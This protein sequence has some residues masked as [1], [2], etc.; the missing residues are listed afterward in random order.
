MRPRVGLVQD[1]GR[2]LQFIQGAFDMARKA[3][4]PA[5][6][7]APPKPRVS[8]APEGYTDLPL[9]MPSV[10][11]A[12]VGEVE[13]NVI[14]SDIY[15]GEKGAKRVIIL[16]LGG[17]P[18]RVIEQGGMR[19][20]FDKVCVG[21]S[22]WIRTTGTRALGGGHTLR[23]FEGAIRQGTNRTPIMVVPANLRAE[24]KFTAPD[25]DGVVAEA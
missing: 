15:I 14:D 13:G 2:Y 3:A 8:A 19:R 18:T 22:V 21:D 17:E 1:S 4:T 25:G 16:D 11:W 24:R 6:S 5:K 20:L 9:D 12:E 10:R 23:T 7:A